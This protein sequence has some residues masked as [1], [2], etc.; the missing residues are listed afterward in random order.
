MAKK[1][2]VEKEVQEPLTEEQRI[3]QLEKKVGSN[4]V[5]LLSIAV[6]LIIIIS[7]KQPSH[8]KRKSLH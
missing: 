7:M 6:F 4:K 1:E 8:Y 5:F 3:A 2:A